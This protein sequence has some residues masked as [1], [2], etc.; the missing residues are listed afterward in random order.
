MAEGREVS[1]IVRRTVQANAKFYKGWLDL[2]LEYFRGISAIFGGTPEATSSVVQESDAAA[3][4]LVLEG[5][6]GATVRGAFLVT[7]DLARNVSCEFVASDFRDPGGATVP[8]RPAFHPATLELG[9]GEQ[10]V[11]QVMLPIDGALAAGVGYAGEFS[12]KGMEGF[13]VP[14]VLRRQHRVEDAPMDESPP[15][16]EETSDAPNDRKTPGEKRATKR[17]ARKGTPP[18]NKQ[19]AS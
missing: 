14:V 6:E 4:A 15:A 1:E 12:I 5:E 11:I 16:G 2:S 8:A 13:A 9:P 17:G 19:S 7:N 3:G 18:R 10:R